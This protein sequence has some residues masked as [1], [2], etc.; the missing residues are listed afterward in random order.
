[1][2]SWLFLLALAAHILVLAFG[3]PA[4]SWEFDEHLFFQALEHYDPLAHHPPPPGYPLFIHFAQLVR[5]V[6]PSD[7]WTL[8]LISVA[9]SIAG[10]V[11]LTLAFRNLLEDEIAGLAG[12]WFFY[13]SP[14]ML[15]HAALP[16]SDSG[17]VALLATALYFSTRPSPALMALFAALAVGWRVQFS[18][19]VVPFF[20]VAVLLM[21]RW[22]DRGVALAVFTAV[23]LAWLTPLAMAVGGVRELIDFETGQGRYLVSHDAAESRSGWTPVRIAF[24]FIGRAWGDE[25]MAAAVLALAAAGGLIVLRK[26]ARSLL[27]F[28]AGAAAYIAVALRLMDPADGVRYSIPFLLLTSL[29]AGTGATVVARRL[30][31]P[32]VVL[33]LAFAA[34]FLAY[35]GPLLFQRRTSISPPVH[36][37]AWAR[38]TQ[39]ENAVV[40]YELPLWPHATYFFGDRGHERVDEG[41]AKYFD[42][43]DVPLFIYADGATRVPGSRV[44][45]WDSSDAYVKLTR[46]HYRAISVI[47]VPPARRFRIVRGVF[48]QERTQEG[49]EW[50]WME[51]LAEIQL[52]DGPARTLTLRAG[53]PS[54]APMEEN[55]LTVSVDG[56][57][58]ISV[59]LNR[60][61]PSVATLA[62][63]AGAPVV[64]FVATHSFIP[65][66]VPAMRSG[67]RRRLA[68][69]LYELRAVAAPPAAPPP[70]P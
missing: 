44:F 70:V 12:A 46:N 25:A 26:H 45:T 58:G 34:V 17:A 63:P 15:I 10:F 2:R 40:L 55:T 19:F 51:P 49:R 59:Y 66:E 39:A 37:A 9:S 8:T 41:L 20:L 1:M 47:P 32:P 50:R 6:V 22:R 64:R 60:G 11:M 14:A 62:V 35:T 7:F 13:L 23:C 52:P 29:A 67:D 56:G 65:A 28:G 43:P 18:I 48:G 5:L 53:L 24:R 61:I 68:A 30:R 36:A 38:D 57:A 69:E 27:P 21:R 4:S 16:G 42:R 3:L 33:P 31:L 54:I